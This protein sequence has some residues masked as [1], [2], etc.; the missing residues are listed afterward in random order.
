M[1]YNTNSSELYSAQYRFL[2]FCSLLFH[3]ALVYGVRV[4]LTQCESDNQQL[5]QVSIPVAAITAVLSV[6]T[7]NKWLKDS[8]SKH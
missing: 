4:Y 3:A 2:K 7:P 8:Q 1:Q 6:L 5:H